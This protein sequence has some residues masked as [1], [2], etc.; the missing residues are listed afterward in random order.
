[1]T[2]RRDIPCF[3][4]ESS[5]LCWSER[6]RS[7]KSGKEL[8]VPGAS[9]GSGANGWENGTIGAYLDAA[10]SWGQASINGLPKLAGY[11][12]PDNPWRRAAQILYIGEIY[13]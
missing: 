5:L 13:E 6:P 3:F 9:H 8:T 7:A 10:T 11:E 2:G 4:L 12:K 1:V